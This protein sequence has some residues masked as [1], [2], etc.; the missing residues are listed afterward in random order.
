MKIKNNIYKNIRVI[1][2]YTKSK[3]YNGEKSY[4]TFR[5]HFDVNRKKQKQKQKTKHLRN[6][7]INSVHKFLQFSQHLSFL[8]NF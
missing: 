4:A 2:E 6:C 7:T 1:T 3:R 5:D 8:L